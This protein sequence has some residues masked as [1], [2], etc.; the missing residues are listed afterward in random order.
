MSSSLLFGAFKG[1]FYSMP[2]PDLFFYS[3]NSKPS[4][5]VI[6]MLYKSNNERAFCNWQLQLLEESLQYRCAYDWCRWATIVEAE[7]TIPLTRFR[8][9]AIMA[10]LYDFVEVMKWMMTNFRLTAETIYKYFLLA[11]SLKSRKVEEFLRSRVE[12]IEIE[13]SCFDEKLCSLID[14]L[15]KF[16]NNSRHTGSASAL[17]DQIPQI[18]YL[19]PNQN[20]LT[21]LYHLI[22]NPPCHCFGGIGSH[23]Y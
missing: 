22:S 10:C 1:F 20:W 17:L 6:E 18:D 4:P 13:S 23:A 3:K 2:H 9:C 5:V 11:K 15:K 19:T 14:H 16:K 8:S 12:I 21:H 7:S